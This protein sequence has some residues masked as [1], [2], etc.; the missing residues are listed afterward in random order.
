TVCKPAAAKSVHVKLHPSFS[1]PDI[2]CKAKYDIHTVSDD[3]AK[4]DQQSFIQLEL[5]WKI[6]SSQTFML[7]HEPHLQARTEVE[8]LR[9][10]IEGLDTSEVNWLGTQEQ[11]LLEDVKELVEKLK[12]GS[13]LV[14]CKLGETTFVSLD[15]TEIVSLEQIEERKDLD[16]TDHLWKI[17]QACTSYVELV[18]TFKY[19]VAE[20]RRGDFQPFINSHNTTTVGQMVKDSYRGQLRTPLLTGLSPLLYLA[21]MGVQKLSRDYLHVFLSRHLANMGMLDYF[22]KGNLELEDKL[23]RLTKLHHSLETVVMLKKYLNLPLECLAKCC[24]EM[25]KYYESHAVENSHRFAFSVPTTAISNVFE[26]FTPTEWSVEG[27][28]M[29]GRERERLVY[30]FTTEQ[31]CDWVKLEGPTASSKDGA[32]DEEDAFY[33]LTIL[34]DSVSIL[35]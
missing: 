35:S 9:S 17:L 28:K 3:K 34:T 1:S 10:V 8:I 15:E 24:R 21:E 33:F 14:E 2:T 12:L 31:P 11:P 27:V 6:L 4:P 22:L 20:L 19:V 26:K 32:E 23:N 29:V 13:D 25:L 30:H 16:F 18:D 7:L 5:E